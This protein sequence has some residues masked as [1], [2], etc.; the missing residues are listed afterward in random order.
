MTVAL[1]LPVHPMAKTSQ[2]P[3]PDDSAPASET[4]RIAHDLMELMREICFH[5]REAKGKRIKLAQ[6]IDNY[7]RPQVVRDHAALRKR[8]AK[9]ED[10]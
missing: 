5:S 7:L 3:E 9:G 8:L 6:L 4:A 2:T 1:E 10:K